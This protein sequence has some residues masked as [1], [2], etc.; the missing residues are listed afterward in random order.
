MLRIG[1]K[2]ELAGCLMVEWV[3]SKKVSREVFD[4]AN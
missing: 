2:G 3:S 4:I 1:E